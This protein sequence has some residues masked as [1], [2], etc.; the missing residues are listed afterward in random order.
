MKQIVKPLEFSYDDKIIHFLMNDDNVMVNATEMANVFGKR[1]DD[2]TRLESTQKLIKGINR[3]YFNHSD[4]S[5]YNLE[6]NENNHADVRDYNLEKNENNH[7]DVRDYNLENIVS[8]NKKRGTYMHRI[9]ALDFAAWLDIDFK[10]WI[11]SVIEKIIFGY[12]KEHWIAHQKQEKAKMKMEEYK[13]KLILNAN[14]ENV[15]NYFEA[16]E[17]YQNAKSMKQRAM[18]NQYKLLL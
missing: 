1:V 16:Q 3:N 2:Y 10:I 11:Y 9:L 8:S 12:Y 18:L 5:D 15:I 6:K 4:V 17:D 13:R 7:A 14:E